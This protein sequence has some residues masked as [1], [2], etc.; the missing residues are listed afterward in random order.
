GKTSGTARNE[1]YASA[2]RGRRRYSWGL[3]KGKRQQTSEANIYLA[4]IAMNIA[5]F[6]R[7]YSFYFFLLFDRRKKTPDFGPFSVLYPILPRFF[8]QYRGLFH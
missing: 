1:G 4:A 2:G 5:R 7:R 6:M 8:F 3:N